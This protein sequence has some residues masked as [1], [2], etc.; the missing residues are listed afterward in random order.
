M[1]NQTVTETTVRIFQRSTSARECP[2]YKPNP[3]PVLTLP[4]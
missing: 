3:N 4:Y 1:T 2:A